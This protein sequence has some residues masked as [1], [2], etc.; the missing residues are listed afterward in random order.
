MRPLLLAACLFGLSAFVVAQKK[1]N[2]YYVA[3]NGDTVS[4]NFPRF[5]QWKNNPSV[6]QFETYDRQLIELTPNNCKSFTVTGFDTYDVLETRRMTNR[7]SFKDDG[8][9]TT[10]TGDE[11][12]ENIKAFLLKVYKADTVSLY[13]FSDMPRP[14]IS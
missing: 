11:T 6:V 4:G 12:Y 7:T 14:E 5:K 1:F 3:L 2:G 8:H 10:E 13:E 9:F